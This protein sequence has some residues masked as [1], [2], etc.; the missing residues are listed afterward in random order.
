MINNSG[1]YCATISIPLN[2]SIKVNQTQ[3]IGRKC[4]P[5]MLQAEL[6][7]PLSKIKFL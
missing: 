1:K 2:S 7:S 3:T 4:K 6:P 5:S